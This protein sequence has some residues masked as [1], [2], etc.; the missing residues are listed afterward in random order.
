MKDLPSLAFG[1]R[2]VTLLDRL[3]DDGFREVMDSTLPKDRT[4]FIR[5]VYGEMVWKDML[6]K[7]SKLRDLRNLNGERYAHSVVYRK[8]K[9]SYQATKTA[10]MYVLDRKG[11]LEFVRDSS[12]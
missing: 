10:V 2:R 3:G 8:L 9:P 6:S 7:S 11:Q 12:E 1:I 5:R 4:G